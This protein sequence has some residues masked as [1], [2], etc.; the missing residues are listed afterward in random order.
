M[1]SVR[2]RREGR[3]V[4]TCVAIGGRF[5]ETPE[6]RAG[7]TAAAVAAAARP[8]LGSANGASA[9]ITPASSKQQGTI[10]KGREEKSSDAARGERFE[11][12][13][14][15]RAGSTAAADAAAA[16][17]VARQRDARPPALLTCSGTGRGA[18]RSR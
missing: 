16:R 4:L 3:E 14:E 9:R 5:E 7:S 10:R 11:E 15:R 18:L 17:P 13:R 1:G 6:R 8:S 12:T 2:G